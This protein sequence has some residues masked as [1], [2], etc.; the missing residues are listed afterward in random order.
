M[1]FA[2][3]GYLLLAGIVAANLKRSKQIKDTPLHGLPIGD[4]LGPM[5]EVKVPTLVEEAVL[6]W[7]WGMLRRRCR[8]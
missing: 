2:H 1:R 6:A 8:S 7:L 3:P 4:V 5:A